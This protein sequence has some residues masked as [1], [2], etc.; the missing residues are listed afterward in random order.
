VA[1][2]Q[3]DQSQA[4]HAHHRITWLTAALAEPGRHCLMAAD[5][6]AEYPAD[7]GLLTTVAVAQVVARRSARYARIT[8]PTPSGWVACRSAAICARNCRSSLIR[9]R[10]PDRAGCMIIHHRPTTGMRADAAYRA[11]AKQMQLP[12]GQGVDQYA[13]STSDQ[14]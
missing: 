11:P 9:Q 1:S 7:S 8:P 2:Y 10:L 4:G 12:S 13:L 3:F 14:W 6:P 5:P